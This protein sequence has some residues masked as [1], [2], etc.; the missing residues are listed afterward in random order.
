[1]L[2]GE[3]AAKGQNELMEEVSDER[4]RWGRGS[5]GQKSEGGR[6][7]WNMGEVWKGMVFIYDDPDSR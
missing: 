1:M 7:G 2:N 3:A 5:E 6:T 4:G